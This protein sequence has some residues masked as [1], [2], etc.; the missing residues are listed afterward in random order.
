MTVYIAGGALLIVLALQLRKPAR[1]R[2]MYVRA[3]RANVTPFSN[4][5]FDPLF[6][7]IPGPDVY[8]DFHGFVEGAREVLEIREAD[9]S[10]VYDVVIHLLKV[11]PD[12]VASYNAWYTLHNAQSM[13]LLD[14]NFMPKRLRKKSKRRSSENV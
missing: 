8:E 10:R 13:M 11:W 14:K 5:Y 1:A 6:N 2:R 4:S 12:A 7:L 9:A 3:K